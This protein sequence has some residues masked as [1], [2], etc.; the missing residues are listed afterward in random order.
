MLEFESK[1]SK[2]GRGFEMRLVKFVRT[3]EGIRVS[4][5]DSECDAEYLLK[6]EQ[7][8]AF[9]EKIDALLAAAASLA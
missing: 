3:A 9:G 6:P 7:Y 4:A 1:I 2:H 5:Y 8:A